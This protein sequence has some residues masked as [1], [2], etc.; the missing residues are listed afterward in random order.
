MRPAVI[1]GAGRL[2]CISVRRAARSSTT[3]VAAKAPWLPE[4]TLHRSDWQHEE[5]PHTSLPINPSSSAR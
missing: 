3:H 5:E 2:V 4:G 1:H